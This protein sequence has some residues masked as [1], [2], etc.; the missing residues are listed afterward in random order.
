MKCSGSGTLP[1]VYFTSYSSSLL[2]WCPTP[3]CHLP[4]ASECLYV[5]KGHSVSFYAVQVAKKGQGL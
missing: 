4:T 5:A 1:L 2:F 3:A